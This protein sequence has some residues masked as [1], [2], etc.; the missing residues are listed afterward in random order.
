LIERA[1]FSRDFRLEQIADMRGGSCCLL[2]PVDSHLVIGRPHAEQLEFRH[3]IKELRAFHQA[4]SSTGR[5]GRNRDRHVP[6]F[7][8]LV[9]CGS[10]VAAA[11]RGG[12]REC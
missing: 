6:Q 12:G 5:S 2:M 3:K 4:V 7:Q 10:R 11:A 8:R 9:V 1:C